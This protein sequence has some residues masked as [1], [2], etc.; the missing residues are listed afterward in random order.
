MNSAPVPAEAGTRLNLLDFDRKALEA[1]CVEQGEKPFRASQLLQWIHQR[2]VDDFA[3]MTDLSKTLRTRWAETCEIRPPAIALTQQSGDGTCKW[4]LQVDATNRVETVFIPEEGRGTLCVSSQVGC[5]LAC[6]FC[7]TARQGFNRN[8]TVAEI[9]GQVWVAQRELGPDRITNVVLMG[10]GEP[11]LNF[12][13][14]VA[15]IRLM[16]DDFAYGLSKRRVTLSTSGVVP[17]LDR[18]G[19]VTDIALAVSLHAP[20]DALRN[21]L[22]PINRKYPIRELLA[23]CKRYVGVDTRRKVTFE[24][25]MLD[26]INDTPAHARALVRLLSH[27]PSKVNLIPFNPFPGSSYR[28]SP[29]D[30]LRRFSDTLHQAGLI[31]TTRKTRGDDIDAACGQLV[32][33]VNDRTRRQ[34]RLATVTP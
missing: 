17:A 10:M 1:F 7:S 25:V 9:I 32:G 24:Y 29:P 22:V 3:A 5:S 16:L 4:L 14:V 2:G 23:A 20:D 12:D 6:S 21:E 30:T 33:W 11:L 31:V 8:L 27:V 28:C 34:F 26:G 15:A 13:N 19:E 18:L